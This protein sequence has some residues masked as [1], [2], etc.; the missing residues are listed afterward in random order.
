M[1]RCVIIGSGCIGLAIARQLSSK[2]ETIVLE[3]GRYAGS[4]LTSRNSQVIHAGIKLILFFTQ[5]L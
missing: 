5:L 2:M 4:V 1:N 3:Q